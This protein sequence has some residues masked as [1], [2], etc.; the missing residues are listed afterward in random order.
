MVYNV[1]SSKIKSLKIKGGKVMAVREILLLGNESLYKICNEIGKEEIDKAKQIFHDLHDT[2][3]D[4]RK[5]MDLE[6]Q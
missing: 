6:G 2:L 5:K 4:F 1:N 3:F